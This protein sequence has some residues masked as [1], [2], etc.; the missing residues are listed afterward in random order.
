A[1]CHYCNSDEAPP[2]SCPEC[3]SSTV[4]YLGS[5]TEKIEA[6]TQTIFPTARIARMDGD[7]MRSGNLYQK[8]LSQFQQ[9][10]IDILIGTQMIA[11]GFDFHNVTLVGVIHADSALN[12]PDF[13]A[14]ERTFQLIA[15]V[16]GRTGRGGKRGLVVVQTFQPEHYAIQ[17]AS[18]GEYENFAREELQFR[19]NLGYP[20]FGFLMRILI[21]GEENL[22]VQKRAENIA[23][24]I[25]KL[26]TPEIEILGPAP[27]PIMRIKNKFRFQLLAKSANPIALQQLQRTCRKFLQSDEQIQCA[28]DVDPLAML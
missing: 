6:L 12:F 23:E 17:K 26:A 21:R 19:E 28:V 11:K 22:A 20:P 9:H 2:E 1:I 24:A 15:Q 16:S 10:E 3:H 14:A 25:R 8:V 18:R 7:S 13:R 4:R 5:G 27:A